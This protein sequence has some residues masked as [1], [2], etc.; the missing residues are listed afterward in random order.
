MI[1]LLIYAIAVAAW[2]IVAA[3]VDARLER[4]VHVP[5]RWAVHIPGRFPA[6]VRQDYARAR[7][8]R[9]RGRAQ[10]KQETEEP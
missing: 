9:A 5:E 3:V 1:W 4:R 7:Q 8:A 2:W 10:Q 6:Y